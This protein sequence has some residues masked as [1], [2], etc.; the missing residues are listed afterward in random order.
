M[1]RKSACAILKGLRPTKLAMFNNNPEEFIRN[2]SKLI[3]D[4]KA[5]MIVEHISYNKLDETYDSD[6]FTKEKSS[7]PITKAYLSTKS[8]Q[9]YVFTDGYAEESTEKKFAKAL[10]AATE[11][12]VYAKLPRS[13][14]IPTPVGNYSPDWAIAFNKGMVKHIFFVAETKGSMNSM[15]LKPVEQAKIDCAKQ[16]FNKMDGSN[17]RYHNVTDYQTL[18][19]VLKSL[20]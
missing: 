17:V 11:V 3:R 13:F 9:D 4:E 16:L 12:C 1:T 2:V 14:Q 19:D 7:Q 8:I 5:T 10:D 18:L 20:D 15:E 6:I